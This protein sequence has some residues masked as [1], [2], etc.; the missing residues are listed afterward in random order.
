MMPGVARIIAIFIICSPRRV[1][2][3]LRHV[4]QRS[5]AHVFSVSL[6]PP[7]AIWI[8]PSASSLASRILPHGSDVCDLGVV[9]ERG[10]SLLSEADRKPYRAAS[11]IVHL[12]AAIDVIT[13]YR[14]RASAVRERQARNHLSRP[15]RTRFGPD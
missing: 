14:R 11:L 6:T 7:M 3:Q 2:F 1:A 13:E 10:R 12:Q 8:L 5:H 15:S 9:A 4:E